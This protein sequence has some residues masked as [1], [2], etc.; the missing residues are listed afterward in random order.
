M[1]S[2]VRRRQVDGVEFPKSC[3]SSQIS[4][5]SCS[6]IPSWVLSVSACA[7]RELCV[8]AIAEVEGPVVVRARFPA[9]Q[10]RPRCRHH[11]ISCV[12]RVPSAGLSEL[13]GGRQYGYAAEGGRAEIGRCSSYS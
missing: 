10:K 9:A 11:P 5:H 2:A 8:L 6:V 7:R 4:P 3:S 12:V 1:R 13:L